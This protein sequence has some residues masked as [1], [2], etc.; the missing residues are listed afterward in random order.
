MIKGM[1]LFLSL[2]FASNSL[3]SQSGPTY[4]TAVS[5]DEEVMLTWLPPGTFLTEGETCDLPIS[6]GTIVDGYSEIIQG[7]N[8]NFENDFQ[9][10]GSATGK[11]VVYQFEVLGNL[12]VTF[13]FL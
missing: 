5:G 7:S 11:D 4:L 2:F 9:N 1:I 6:G 12:D 8:V 3:L 10:G 13:S